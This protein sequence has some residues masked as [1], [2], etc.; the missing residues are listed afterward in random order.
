MRM[1]LDNGWISE[2]C[3]L[4]GWKGSKPESFAEV[5]STL[6]AVLMSP[7]CANPIFTHH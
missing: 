1:D 6:V 4:P 5:R 7:R 3:T 2:L